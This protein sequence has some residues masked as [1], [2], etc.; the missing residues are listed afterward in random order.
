MNILLLES[1]IS[2]NCDSRES[3]AKALRMSRSRLDAKI[4]GVEE[5]FR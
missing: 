3:L 4:R 1:A 5:E 2:K